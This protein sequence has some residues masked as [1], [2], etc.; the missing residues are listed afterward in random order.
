MHQIDTDI[1]MDTIKF[2]GRDSNQLT[3]DDVICQVLNGDKRFF[4]ILLRRYNQTLFRAVRSYVKDED[5]VSDIMQDAY[6]K[7]FEKL[8]QFQGKSSFA[9]WLVRIGINE[10]LQRLRKAKRK[11]T[12]LEE[13]KAEAINIFQHTGIYTMNPEKKIIQKETRSLIEHAIDQLPEQYKIVYMLREVEGMESEEVAACLGLTYSNVKVRLYR[14]KSMLKK[15]L[16][17]LSVPQNVFEFG[18]EKCD[19]MVEQVMKKILA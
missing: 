5:T 1:K 13:I 7:A 16:E 17:E 8:D 19:Q 9:T 4:E 3:D 12:I 11:L 15:R 14:A 6:L 18:N 2:A 10:A